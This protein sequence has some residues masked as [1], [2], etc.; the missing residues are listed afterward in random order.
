MKYLL[1]WHFLIFKHFN[2]SQTILN[3]F[4]YFSNIGPPPPPPTPPPPPRW[5]DPTPVGEM[6]EVWVIYGLNIWYTHILHTYV[7]CLSWFVATWLF[8]IRD[9]FRKQQKLSAG[10]LDVTFC[11][12]AIVLM[13]SSATIHSMR[14]H[15]MSM[16]ASQPGRS[17]E[18]Q[19]D[20][21]ISWIWIWTY[22]P[23]ARYVKLRVAHAPEMPGKFSPPPRGSDTDMHHGTCVTHVSWYKPGSLT[24]GFVWSRWGEKRSRQF[25]VSGKR[26][27]AERPTFCSRYFEIH[28]GQNPITRTTV[29]QDIIAGA[30]CRF[31]VTMSH[32]HSRQRVIMD[33]LL[34]SSYIR[35]DKISLYKHN[36][37][38]SIY[39]KKH[40]NTC[41]IKI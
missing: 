41:S 16:C 13:R 11:V 26:S 38:N 19:V 23:L 7:L 32:N 6:W 35:I 2:T 40:K 24:S 20:V 37:S 12:S 3:T 31:Q 10:Y 5:G 9:M 17:V 30:M 8:R 25:Y 34:I 14:G 28:F 27:I 36:I 21:R 1:R 33:G 39:K 15:E 4:L 22:G 29:T 18:G